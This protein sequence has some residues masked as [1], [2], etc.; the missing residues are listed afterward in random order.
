MD[1]VRFSK[2]SQKALA[3]EIFGDLIL[4]ATDHIVDH[5]METYHFTAARRY[6]ALNWGMKYQAG[7]NDLD[8]INS[9]QWGPYD[10]TSTLPDSKSLA[11]GNYKPSY[12]KIGD[13]ANA[14]VPAAPYTTNLSLIN[15]TNFWDAWNLS[16]QDGNSRDPGKVAYCWYPS[17]VPFPS[18]S[19]AGE[20]DFVSEEDTTNLLYTFSSTAPNSSALTVDFTLSGTASD[21]VD[22]SPLPSSSSI[23]T[24]AQQQLD[25]PLSQTS[26]PQILVQWAL[27]ATEEQRSLALASYE[28]ILQQLIHTA[29]MQACG[30]GVMEVI[31]LLPGT[32]VDLVLE[33]YKHTAGVRYA[34]L[35][36][37]V[38]SQAV[39]ND[40]YYTNG[41]QWGAYIQFSRGW[42]S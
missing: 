9:S 33:A 28:G 17:I 26:Y 39:S 37:V 42:D 24:Q 23:V 36:R 16:S 38:Q 3:Q 6:D 18:I 13:L 7:G 30:D 25:T 4:A 20:P 35:N 15:G 1:I 14:L 8:C 34:E 12:Y 41:S 2:P 31:K 40:P 29:V 10:D 27:N 19:V 5:A 22:F 32:N 11:S 21:G